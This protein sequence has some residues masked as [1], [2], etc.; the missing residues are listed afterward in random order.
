MRTRRYPRCVAHSGVADAAVL[1]AAP[2]RRRLLRVHRNA[3]VR[4]S[5]RAGSIGA[6][7]AREAKA[8]RARASASRMSRHYEIQLRG[9]KGFTGTLTDV[10]RV[11]RRIHAEGL[12]QRRSA[13]GDF[14]Q[15]SREHVGRAARKD[16]GARSGRALASAE[17]APP[18]SR[19]RPTGRPASVSAA[20]CSRSRARTPSVRFGT[21]TTGTVSEMT[22][23]VE[24]HP[25]MGGPVLGNITGMG[26]DNAHVDGNGHGPVRHADPDRRSCW[27]LPGRSR[28][29]RRADA[30]LRA[31]AGPRG[32]AAR[33]LCSRSRCSAR[34][35]R[36]ASTAVSRG[37]ACRA[38][39][40]RAASCAGDSASPSRGSAPARAARPRAAG[41]ARDSSAARGSAHTTAAA[42]RR[43]GARGGGGTS[44]SD[45]SP[46]GAAADPSRA[47][48]PCADRPALPSRSVAANT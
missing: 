42:R 31:G 24:S 4:G 13:L 37:A 14:P 10:L 35:A 20:R 12:P 48:G 38:R 32:A 34:G 1:A 26:F 18:R 36:D 27:R 28:G 9:V 23:V 40:L 19:S 6:V 33:R 29:D 25:A 45:C 30:H 5:L 22:V 7:P 46:S 47:A 39:A 8:S 2:A 41:R 3:L 43:G 44:T 16:G 15:A 17:I 11:D 21:W